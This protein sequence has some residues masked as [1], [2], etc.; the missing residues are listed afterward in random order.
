MA[1]WLLINILLGNGDA[2]LKNWTL[3][4]SDVYFPLL[5][6]LYDVVLTSPY[7]ENDSLALN[8]VGTKQW[9]EITMKHF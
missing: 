6:P 4:Y 1:R 3:I 5:S 7:I 8:M 2:Y 9:F